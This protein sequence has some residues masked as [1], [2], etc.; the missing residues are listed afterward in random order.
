MEMREQI[1]QVNKALSQTMDL[2]RLWAKKCNLNYHALLILYTLNDYGVCTQKQICEW[3]ALPK[4]TVHGILLDFEKKGY[5]NIEMN[6][7]NKR[8]RFIS[9]TKE[10]ASFSK[11]VLSQ[12]HQMEEQAMQ[13]LGAERSQQLLDCTMD[14]CKLL[15]KEMENG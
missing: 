14:Y 1:K 12:L 13:Q 9:F 6:P 3:W 8:E 2:Y 10:G 7:E 11:A 15:R 4:Q 5:L